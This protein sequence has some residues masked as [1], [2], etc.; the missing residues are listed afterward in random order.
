M[1]PPKEN[2][3]S[4]SNVA[5]AETDDG[6]PPDPIADLSGAPGGSSLILQSGVLATSFTGELPPFVM[7]N[8]VDGDTSTFWSTPGRGSPTTEELTWDLTE[9]VTVAQVRLHSR[10]DFGSLFPQ[11]FEIQLSTDGANFQSVLTVSDFIA[12]DDTWYD[13]DVPPTDA[14][15]VRVAADTVQFTPAAHYVQMAEI[16]VKKEVFSP[17]GSITL[18]WTAP[19]EDIGVPTSGPATSYE[20]HYSPNP[21]LDEFDFLGAIPVTVGVPDPP[22]TPD[23]LEFMSVEGFGVEEI[24]YFAVRAVDE[25]GNKSD[26][27][28]G[29]KVATQ[30]TPPAKPSGLSIIASTGSSLTIQWIHSGDDGMDP[31][32]ANVTYD[33][34]Y[35]TNPIVTVA[36]FDAASQAPGVPPTGP[37][38]TTAVFEVTGLDN[39]TFY[40]VAIRAIDDA[41]NLS[42]ISDPVSGS[43]DDEVAPGQAN[44]AVTLISNFNSVNAP[45]QSSSGA[46]SGFPAANTTDGDA[47]TFWST[48]GR[49]GQVIEQVTV[50]AMS[51]QNLGRVVLTARADLGAL[52][53]S[54]FSIQLSLDGNVYTTVHQKTS[55][56]A[57]PGGAYVFDFGPQ[58]ARYLRVEVTESNLFGL[59]RYVQIAEIDVFVSTGAAV[60]VQLAWTAPGDDDFEA[61]TTAAAYDLRLSTAGPINEGNFSS[62]TPIPGVPAPQAAGSQE[63]FVASVPGETEV[64]FA[65]RTS[66]EV[67]NVSLVSNSPSL[68]TPGIPPATPSDFLATPFDETTIRL[69][70]TAVSD[71]ANLPGLTADEY[72]LRYDVNPITNDAEFLA[73][74]RVA[75]PAPKQQG[76]PEQVDVGAL[77]PDTD[78]YF[79]LRVEDEGDNMSGIANDDAH[80]VDSVAPDPIVDFS[81]VTGGFELE[82][83]PAPAISSSGN[84]SSTFNFAKT[85]DENPGTFWST[86]AR[87]SATN[88]EQVTVDLGSEMLV[89]QIALLSRA[90][91]AGLFPSDFRLQVS[92]DNVNFT[93]VQTVVGFNADPGTWYNFNS[94][95]PMMGRYVRVQVD[96][97]NAYGTV[98]YAQI[99]ETDAFEAIP[100]G[101]PADLDGDGR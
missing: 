99:A 96:T 36:D 46:F 83:R 10:A 34:R 69:T 95:A 33:V 8:T 56:V 23:G 12:A 72:D 86:P 101:R 88:P 77:P 70:W 82:V 97:M 45:T 51:P 55:F 29:V 14:Q 28:P 67:L 6:I 19:H 43:T 90:D 42:P 60:S 81:A 59:L 84:F 80:T 71:D 41:D 38:N 2:V 87:T 66:D 25:S 3:S 78:L 65:L 30:G 73:A 52:F 9:V 61:G 39:E 15:F 17:G 21:I 92:S 98:F 24:N 47:S 63:S 49:S 76:Q 91:F 48:P 5:S 100:A 35:S 32:T 93:T 50:D 7:E 89:G 13:F 31:G 58:M 20:V 44:L 26:V 18:Q 64:Y 4:L 11:N 54:T 75:I 68:M 1:R 53:P 79:A 16:E 22:A 57:D 62:A 40:H 27:V 94:F 37:P 85:T 74:T